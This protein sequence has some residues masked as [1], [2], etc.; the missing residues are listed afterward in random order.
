MSAGWRMQPTERAEAIAVAASVF[1]ATGMITVALHTNSVAVLA[2]G[3]DTCVDIVTSL[4]VM[5]GL[6]LSQ[7]RSSSFPYGL[8]KIE[9]LVTVAIGVLI[10]YSAYALAR[11][12]VSDLLSGHEQISNPGVAMAT[13]AVV[14]TITG[15]LA[16][17]KARV[18]R[19]E[20]SPSLLAD[21]RHSWTDAMASAGIVVGVG[22]DALGV[23][24]VDSLM[25]LV[26][27][28]ILA[29]S[30]VQLLIE[31]IKV[32]LDASLEPAVLETARNTA[33]AQNGVLQVVRVDGRNSGSYRFLHVAITP[34]SDDV[35]AAEECVGRVKAAIMAAVQNVEAVDVELVTADTG[36][37]VVAVL[38][39]ADAQTI[40]RGTEA[41]AT[42]AVLTFDPVTGRSDSAVV[43]AS[44]T[45]STGRAASG[46]IELAVALTKSGADAVVVG[47]PLPDSAMRWVFTA[48]ELPLLVRATS[49]RTTRPGHADRCAV[50]TGVPAPSCHNR[51]IGQTV[52]RSWVPGRFGL[53][54]GCLSPSP[55]SLA[56][57]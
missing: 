1:M 2:E 27:A 7:R 55:Q 34:V 28:A 6:R 11:E 5:I 35:E 38:L 49:T 56:E 8:Y 50:G 24:F 22:L 41:T 47:A 33:A 9:N 26:I 57:G 48:Y 45:G 17:N 15:L 20:N 10:L 43:D 46:P 29:W 39:E 44:G 4:A 42:F 23:P 19:R 37:A 31:A 52:R 54:E 32:L 18:G 51:V 3:I 21:A 25:A 12:A 30:G 40:A 16:W 36:V 13:M 14:A 53:A